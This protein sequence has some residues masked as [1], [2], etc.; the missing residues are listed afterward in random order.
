[1]CCVM[2]VYLNILP[3]FDKSCISYSMRRVHDEGKE[4]LFCCLEEEN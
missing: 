1:M 2:A 4:K 3:E